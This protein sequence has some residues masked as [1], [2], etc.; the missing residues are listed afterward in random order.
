MRKDLLYNTC[1]LSVCIHSELENCH[2][3]ET[4]RPAHCS[5]MEERTE[6]WISP[7]FSFI[8][9]ATWQPTIWSLSDGFK[10]SLLLVPR[11]LCLTELYIPALQVFVQRHE[12]HPTHPCVCASVR[13]VKPWMSPCHPSGSV[14]WLCKLKETDTGAEWACKWNV[15]IWEM[16]ELVCDLHSVCSPKHHYGLCICVWR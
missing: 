12:Y 3:Y 15:S 9:P 2:L 1:V 16:W 5:T 6:T 4:V 14:V 10:A 11:A 13:V 7:I 8:D